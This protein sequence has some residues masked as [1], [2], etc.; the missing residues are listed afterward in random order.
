MVSRS[1]WGL[2][3]VVAVLLPKATTA[4]FDASHLELDGIFLHELD[5][6]PIRARHTNT[7]I[8]KKIPVD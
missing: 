7:I 4:I 2:I 1:W 5:V 6:V 3:G 8:T